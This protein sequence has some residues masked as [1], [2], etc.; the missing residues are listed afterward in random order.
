MESETKLILRSIGL[1]LSSAAA[2]W[3]GCLTTQN[4]EVA[5]AA[6]VFALGAMGFTLTM[7]ILD[8]L[9]I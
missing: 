5:N 3:F 6:F 8:N 9:E 7:M 1:A 2:G 4:N